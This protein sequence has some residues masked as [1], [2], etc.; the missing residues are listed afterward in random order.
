MKKLFFYSLFVAYTLLFPCFHAHASVV[1]NELFPKPSDEVSEW[2]ELYNNGVDAVDL[3]GW[4]LENTNG[5]KKVYTFASGTVIQPYTF[6]TIFQL[7]TS[8]SLNNGG[9]TVKLTNANNS[10]ADSKGFPSTIGYNYSMGRDGDGGQ[11][12]TQCA[13]ATFNKP[14]NCPAPAPTATPYPT[15]L[16]TI[17]PTTVIWPTDTPTPTIDLLI[18]LA[19]KAVTISGDI[20]DISTDPESTSTPIHLLTP[21]PILSSDDYRTRWAV[22]LMAGVAIGCIL[23]FYGI[24]KS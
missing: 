23:F 19:K 16:P 8:I 17:T 3:G 5:D 14:N 6:L 1:I 13:E 2:I 21:T 10:E 20:Q 12:W 11:I 24:I 18:T 15:Q 7:Q 4:K 9:D 22:G